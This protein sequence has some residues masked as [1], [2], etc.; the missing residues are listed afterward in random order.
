[1]IA[2]VFRVSQDTT[3][4]KYELH[5]SVILNS[6][7]TLHIGNDKARFTELTL[8][9][10][11]NFLYAGDNHVQIEAYGT[12]EVIIQ[13]NS[14]PKGRKIKL[15]KAAFILLFH[16]SIISLQLLNK[17]QVYWNNRT[18]SLKY[19]KDRRHFADTP[20]TYGQWVLEYNIPPKS[21][22]QASVPAF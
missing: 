19:S 1:M 22:F 2:R 6:R 4:P 13:T 8:A 17:H 16:T 21:V 7:A 5:S 3:H 11:S 12:I 10:N 14:Y 9:N 20:I 15:T 18:N